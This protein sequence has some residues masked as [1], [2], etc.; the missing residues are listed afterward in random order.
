MLVVYLNTSFQPDKFYAMNDPNSFLEMND[1]KFI[2]IA[3]NV[4][5][6]SVRGICHGAFVQ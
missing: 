5:G 4:T 6:V 2:Q 1:S 3:R